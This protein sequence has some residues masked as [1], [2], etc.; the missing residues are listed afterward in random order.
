VFLLN[1][2]TFAFLIWATASLD[3]DRLIAPPVVPRDK[4]GLRHA[5]RYV[6]RRPELLLLLFIGFMMGNFGF[7]FGISNPVMASMVFGKGPTEFGVLGSL[8]GLGALG[9]ALLS[10]SR[11]KSRLRYIL[12]AMAGYVVFQGASGLV[13]EFWQFAL[14]QVPIGLCAITTL[15]TA[16]TLL[17]TSVAG[18]VRGRVM[19]LWTMFLLGASPVTG[20]LV[21]WIG[22][23]FGPRWTVQVGTISIAATFVSVMVY[24]MAHEGVRMRLNWSARRPIVVYYVHG[25]VQTE[26]A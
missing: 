8:M 3:P 26:R 25:D 6:R 2:L 21:G 4:G 11:S 15:V 1:T 5:L 14:L 13:G 7:N 12:V 23:T 9:A 16:N 17:Q 24:L 20:P 18:T 22:T 10:A 19:A